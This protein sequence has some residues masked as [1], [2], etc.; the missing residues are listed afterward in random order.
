MADARSLVVDSPAMGDQGEVDQE[1]EATAKWPT[2]PDGCPSD[3]AKPGSGS[4]YRMVGAGVDD[5][6]LPVEIYGVRGDHP[7]CR[8]HAFSI[9]TDPA[10][11]AGHRKKYKSLRNCKIARVQLTQDMGVILSDVRDNNSHNSWWP[12]DTLK[13]PPNFEIVED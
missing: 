6:R 4:F 11:L 13:L 7:E 8:Q 5:W 10:H 2:R 3:D 1:P 9:Y 12:S